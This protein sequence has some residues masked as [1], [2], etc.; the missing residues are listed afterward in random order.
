MNSSLALVETDWR[1]AMGDI[2]MNLRREISDKASREEMF[3]T[4]RRECDILERRLEVRNSPTLKLILKGCVQ[5]VE[6]ELEGLASTENVSKIDN[7]VTIL[8]AKVAGELTGARWL[9]TSGQIVEGG[10]IPWDTEVI[11]AAPNVLMWKKGGSA[12][13]VRLSGL[14]R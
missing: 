10:W 12:I 6:K 7:E 5:G 9:W 13:K 14:Y 11:N 8:R 1:L 2:S 3:G 4:I